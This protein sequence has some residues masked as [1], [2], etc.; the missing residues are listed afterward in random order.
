VLFSRENGNYGTAR[1]RH[2]RDH[3]R[4]QSTNPHP[5]AAKTWTLSETGESVQDIVA[6]TF[7]GGATVR[8]K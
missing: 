6:G 7:L 2:G 1:V 4:A 5:A 8:A 3:G